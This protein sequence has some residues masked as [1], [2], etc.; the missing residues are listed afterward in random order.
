MRSTRRAKTGAK[1]GANGCEGAH[2]GDE[3]WVVCGGAVDFQTGAGGIQRAHTEQS[4]RL[5]HV[6]ISDVWSARHASDAFAQAND[7]FKL[8]DC[9][10]D[11]AAFADLEA[12][13]VA[14]GNELVAKGLARV[15]REAR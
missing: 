14:D 11:N 7:C 5:R 1:T 9:D 12:V 2:L 13:L 6:G 8:T 4:E 15:N 10:G 3:I